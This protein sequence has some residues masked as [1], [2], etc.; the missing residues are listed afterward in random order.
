MDLLYW[1]RKRV[2]PVVLAEGSKTLQKLFAATEMLCFNVIELVPNL[3]K[4]DGIDSVLLLPKETLDQNVMAYG[5]RRASEASSASA[6]ADGDELPPV[7]NSLSPWERQISDQSDEARVR[8]QNT[9]I[10]A[11]RE[12]RKRAQ[13]ATQTT[14]HEALR[15]AR[16]LECDVLIMPFLKRKF[17]PVFRGAVHEVYLP[18]R[19]FFVVSNLG[20]MLYVVA[21]N[22]F[23]GELHH[24]V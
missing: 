12:K 5:E 23:P 24:R 7:M 10:F 19:V 6:A 20:I 8:Q 2:E 1:L 11:R 17:F 16:S 15:G 21:S 3:S 22:T 9:E 13:E 4:T 14:Q 18:F